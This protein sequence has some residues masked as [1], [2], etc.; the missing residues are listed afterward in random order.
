[1]VA[2]NSLPTPPVRRSRGVTRRVSEAA[3]CRLPAS[4]ASAH[5]RF[6]Q[7]P[8]VARTGQSWRLVN[9]CPRH[10]AQIRKDLVVV[11][12]CMV[13]KHEGEQDSKNRGSQQEETSVAFHGPQIGLTSCLLGSE[14][15]LPFHVVGLPMS[16][17]L[18]D[19]R[20]D[21]K[22]KAPERFR[23]FSLSAQ[24][25]VCFVPKPEA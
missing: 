23:G 22:T 13:I 10:A 14:A 16:T 19:K 1:M 5:V 21:I 9:P 17:C 20:S 2:P 18:G 3:P 8:S 15:H 4:Q 25:D 24:A 6:N 7:S 11:G 12:Y